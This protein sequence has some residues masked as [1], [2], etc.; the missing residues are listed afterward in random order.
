[1]SANVPGKK[2]EFLLYM[3]GIPSWHKACEEAL[4]G[5]KGFDVRGLQENGVRGGES[6]PVAAPNLRV[7]YLG[8]RPRPDG[9][10]NV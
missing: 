5:W 8:N 7:A 4:E 2:R 9:C 3:G 6:P 10:W 1:M